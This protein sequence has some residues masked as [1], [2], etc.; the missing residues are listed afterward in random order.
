MIDKILKWLNKTAL[1]WIK[2]DGWVFII[3]I[4]VIFYA[5]GKLT[6]ETGG[7]FIV[8]FWIWI[9]AVYGFFWKLLGFGKVLKGYIKQQREKKK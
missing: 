1:P 5:Y 7:E 6:P 2:D 3:S 8:G 4:F 9:M